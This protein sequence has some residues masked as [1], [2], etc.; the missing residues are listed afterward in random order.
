MDTWLH[1]DDLRLTANPV[2]AVSEMLG[3]ESYIDCMEIIA[4]TG[5]GILREEFAS[6]RGRTDYG[7]EVRRARLGAIESDPDM[8][9]V[10]TTAD[11][12]MSYSLAQWAADALHDKLLY[13]NLHWPN[14]D[15][16]W[17]NI[18]GNLMDLDGPI[19]AG[20]PVR[21]VSIAPL[22]RF[23]GH[24]LRYLTADPELH[25]AMSSMGELV[26]NSL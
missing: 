24:E 15:E 7:R 22:C 19:S 21:N 20:C 17:R 14:T 8:I 16:A 4:T 13:Q 2:A 6:G 9:Q 3:N 26:L 25:D 23:L 18:A 1:N 11:G 5:F 12:S 10:N